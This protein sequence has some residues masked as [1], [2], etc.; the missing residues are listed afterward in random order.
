M[1]SLLALKS[2]IFLVCLP[3]TP[4]G[5][6][7]RRNRPNEILSVRC[8]ELRLLPPPLP[9]LVLGQRVMLF[10]AFDLKTSLTVVVDG[11]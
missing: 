9:S 6:L 2:G 11:A 1:L 7:W 10:G 4:V 8:G 3:S 5:D